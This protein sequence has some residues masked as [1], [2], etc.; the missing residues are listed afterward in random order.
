LYRNADP[1][2]NSLEESSG[3]G[4]RRGRRRRGRRSRDRRRRDR[5]SWDRK[6]WEGDRKIGNRSGSGNGSRDRSGGRFRAAVLCPR[7]LPTGT[8][9][10]NGAVYQTLYQSRCAIGTSGKS[11]TRFRCDYLSNFA[12]KLIEI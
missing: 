7:R 5:K 8:T 1:R 4:N 9:V 3:F 11:R 12:E 2:K 10:E 6:S